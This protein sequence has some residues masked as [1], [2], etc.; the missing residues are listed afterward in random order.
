MVAFKCKS[1]G[2][3]SFGCVIRLGS[4]SVPMGNDFGVAWLTSNFF[5]PPPSTATLAC[6]PLRASACS[7]LSARLFHPSVYT[8]G[9]WRL[10]CYAAWTP[11][12]WQCDSQ[13]H[14]YGIKLLFRRRNYLRALLSVLS[15]SLWI[16]SSLIYFNR[17][18][19]SDIR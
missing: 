19:S 7:T 8:P 16:A 14:N 5:P 11:F 17:I 3:E 9:Y 15:T 10:N 1:L 4:I 18:A 12:R 13:R 2:S 6:V